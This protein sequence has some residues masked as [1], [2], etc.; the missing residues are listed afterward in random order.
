MNSAGNTSA[1][2]TEVYYSTRNNSIQSNGLS[3]YTMA[4]M[5]LKNI[6]SNLS[7][8]NRGVKSNVFVV[9]NMNTVPAVLIEYGFLSNSSDLAKFSRLDVQD[10]A[11]EILYDTIEE[12]FDNYPTG[13]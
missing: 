8:A 11:A 2:G 1:K 7:M 9:T 3:S 6:T 4:S 10:K 13:R 12:I 5:F